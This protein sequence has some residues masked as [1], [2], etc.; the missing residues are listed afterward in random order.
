VTSSDGL[1]SDDAEADGGGGLWRGAIKSWWR[2]LHEK[3]AASDGEDGGAFPVTRQSG[4][5]AALTRCE[6]LDD[7]YLLQPFWELRSRHNRGSD[8]QVACI[9]GVLAHVRH[10]DGDDP[11][12]AQMADDEVVKSNRFERLLQIDERE[13]LLRP[14]IRA[15]QTMDRRA[16]VDRLAESIF[17]WGKDVRKRW[18]KHYWTT[19]ME[20]ADE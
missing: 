14:L 1:R 13:E 4:T 18:A 10:D 2:A 6:S 12:G 5:R 7:I 3:E 17:F 15:V 16:N 9:A 8:S 11:V 20:D 19:L